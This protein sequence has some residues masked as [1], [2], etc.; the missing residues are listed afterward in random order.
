MAE[1][2]LPSPEEAAR[3]AVGPG[4]VSWRRAGDARTMVGAGTALLLQVAHPSV[5]AGVREHSDFRA[6]PW[7]RL[8]RT[9]DY[10]NLLVYGGPEAAAETGARMRAMHRRIKGTAPDGTRYHALEPEAYAWVHATLAHTIVQVHRRFG[11]PMSGAMT[12]QFYAEWRGLG[13]LLGIRERDLPEGWGAFCAYFDEMVA[14]RLEHNDVVDDVLATL[15]LPAPPP[16]PGM[17]ERTWRLVGTPAA[18]AQTLATVGLLP[19]LLRE[20]CG[21]TWT[22]TQE[23]ELSALGAMMRSATPVM[24]RSMRMLGPSYLKWRRRQIAG[25]MFGPAVEARAGD[26]APAAA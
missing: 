2:I 13:R 23:L 19:P 10:V 9:L 16:V 25:G 6:D 4:S 7:G 15:A 12:E 3:Y 5:G 8:F 18:R 14:T 21:L 24:P 20:R 22:R 11:R 26:R 17:G 1:S